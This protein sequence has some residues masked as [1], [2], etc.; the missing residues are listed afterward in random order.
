LS[1]CDEVDFDSVVVDSDGCKCIYGS[2]IYKLIIHEATLLIER[3]C[4]YKL[5]F[6]AIGICD[7]GC[8]W[9]SGKVFLVARQE[10]RTPKD[11]ARIR[12]LRIVLVIV[13]PDKVG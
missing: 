11:E 9:A 13:S 4:R 5:D 6:H 7:Y 2:T 3:M 8:F 12:V 10:K 1:I